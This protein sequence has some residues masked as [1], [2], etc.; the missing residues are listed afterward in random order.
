MDLEGQTIQ[1]FDDQIEEW[2]KEGRIK[3]I[4]RVR[5]QPVQPRE[6]MA[7]P[8]VE[9]QVG[10]LSPTSARRITEMDLTNVFQMPG[11]DKMIPVMIN[12]TGPTEIGRF[13]GK[14]IK[15]AIALR[16]LK[17]K[18]DGWI[19]WDADDALHADVAARLGFPEYDINP[20]ILEYGEIGLD[21]LPGAY[22]VDDYFAALD[23][24]IAKG[25]VR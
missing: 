15:G 14:H 10:Q 12:P 25:M 3:P 23:E 2:I 18:Q 24:D 13:L 8:P 22:A 11:N 21:E 6:G 5:Q 7:T 17:T 9:Y 20:D 19:I 4:A 16:Y 1:K